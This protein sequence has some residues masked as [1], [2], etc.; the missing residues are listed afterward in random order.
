V[1][2]GLSSNAGRRHL[3]W[4]LFGAVSED[5]Q[6]IV[7]QRVQSILAFIAKV[8]RVEERIARLG[9]GVRWRRI[10]DSRA[11]RMGMVDFR[12][13]KPQ[14]GGS[15]L[16]LAADCS[17]VVLLLSRRVPG[18]LS[19]DGEDIAESLRLL[20]LQQDL[21]AALSARTRCGECS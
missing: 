11:A 18:W 21:C 19:G 20:L 6:R 4:V 8:N 16:G 1:L 14:L 5:A 12:W 3:F 7:D 10:V 17:A 15:H 9:G 13:T 2:A